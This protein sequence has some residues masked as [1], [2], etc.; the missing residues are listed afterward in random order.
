MSPP[1]WAPNVTARQ[2]LGTRHAEIHA[3]T[4]TGYFHLMNHPDAFDEDAECVDLDHVELVALGV[5]S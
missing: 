1:Y 2:P 4:G 5:S 3:Y